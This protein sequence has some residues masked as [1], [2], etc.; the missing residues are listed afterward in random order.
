M[1]LTHSIQVS[2]AW[3]LPDKHQKH[4][5]P[6]L[7]RPSSCSWQKTKTKP[8]LQTEQERPR[9][10]YVEM[11]KKLGPDM[12]WACLQVVCRVKMGDTN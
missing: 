4:S 8:Y 12:Q 10:P 11:W 6:E 3:I 9:S 7:P 1:L 2:I 5:E